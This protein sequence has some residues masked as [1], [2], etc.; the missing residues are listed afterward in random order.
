MADITRNP[1]I[2]GKTGHITGLFGDLVKVFLG[3]FNKQ[4]IYPQGYLDGF[5]S[6]HT[7]KL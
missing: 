3:A 5:L 6:V 2:F 4:A 1:H 7:Q